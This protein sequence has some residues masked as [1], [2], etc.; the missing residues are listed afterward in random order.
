ML[1][2]PPGRELDAEVARKVFRYVVMVDTSTGERYTISRD[3]GNR[4]PIEDFSTS[5]DEAYRIIDMM[6]SNGLFAN[7]RNNVEDGKQVWHVGFY[8]QGEA[9]YSL[10]KGETLAHAT[11]L[12]VLHFMGK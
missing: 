12:A 6:K 7:I 10:I 2:L 9:T 4:R 3:T 8:R 1:Y 5:S 11:C